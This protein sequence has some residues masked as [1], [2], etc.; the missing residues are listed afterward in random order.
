MSSLL[1]LGFFGGNPSDTN[2]SDNAYFEWSYDQFT[3]LMGARPV[4]M[5]A[6]VDYTLDP[7]LWAANAQFTASSWAATGAS[8]VGPTSGTVPV[9]GIPMSSPSGSW[10][11]CRSVVSGDHLGP[12]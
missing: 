9:I 10:G 7:S 12:V 1:P 11:E 5:N 4:S 3:A 2:A 8:Y 6:Y